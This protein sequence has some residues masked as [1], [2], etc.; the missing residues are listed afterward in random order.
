[1][2]SQSVKKRAVQ[3]KEAAKVPAPRP[4]SVRMSI[5][6]LY[7]AAFISACFLILNGQVQWHEDKSAAF[8]LQHAALVHMGLSVLA[9][10]LAGFLISRCYAWGRILLFV[11][12]VVSLAVHAVTFPH[13]VAISP[14][15]C[16]CRLLAL[17]MEISAVILC[18]LPSA[19]SWFASLA[20]LAEDDSGERKNG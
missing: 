17:L 10:A 1:M 6:C 15:F 7:G 14:G 16:I 2:S 11:L 12:A 8:S 3:E 5:V 4:E 19:R 9:D 13:V 20:P 18:L